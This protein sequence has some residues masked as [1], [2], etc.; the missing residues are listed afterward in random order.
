MSAPRPWLGGLLLTLAA[1]CAAAEV[2]KVEDLLH[3]NWHTIEVIIFERATPLGQPSAEDLLRTQERVYPANLRRLADSAPQPADTLHQDTRAC[4]EQPLPRPAT[5]T[6]VPKGTA[7]SLPHPPLLPEP[8]PPG[9]QLPPP[10]EPQL[11]PHPL[12]RLLCAAAAF[13]ASL[14]Q[15]SHRWLGPEHL[16]LH[17][18][19]DRIR[20][21]QNLALLWHGGW[22]QPAPRPSD[23]QPLLLQLGQ[24]AS[25]MHQLEGFL[26]VTQSNILHFRALLWRQASPAPGRPAAAR[27]GYM[28]LDQSRALRRG[29]LHYLDHPKLGILV[30]IRLVA[31]PAQLQEALR[32]WRKADQEGRASGVSEPR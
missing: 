16:R 5:P 2:E 1:V 25:G 19:A 17:S 10:I 13:E 20:N 32:A 29:E 4:L 30:Q 11:A 24:R 31:P 8:T 22:T 27:A 18:Q 14:R 9:V 26:E 3:G 21:A 15:R 7:N 6:A 12:L 28:T 23:G